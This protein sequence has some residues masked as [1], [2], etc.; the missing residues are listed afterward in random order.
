MNQTAPTPPPVVTGHRGYSADLLL[1]P[2]L[3]NESR[4]GGVELT[5]RRTNIQEQGGAS[6]VIKG[7]E[8]SDRKARLRIDRET[9]DPRSA[10][11]LCG[12]PGGGSERPRFPTAADRA[13]PEG[14]AQHRLHSC[15]RQAD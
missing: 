4:S 8:G 6:S 5:I 15:R 14:P 11:L 2:S 12:R 9:G 10:L 13:G 7:A 3:G 1:Q